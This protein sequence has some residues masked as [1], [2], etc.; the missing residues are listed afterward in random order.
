MAPSKKYL[1][2]LASIAYNSFSDKNFLRDCH[3]KPNDSLCLRQ[4]IY[5]LSS[6]GYTLTND[7]SDIAG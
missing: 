5:P 1:V 7:T 3:P 4:N 6:T 2:Y